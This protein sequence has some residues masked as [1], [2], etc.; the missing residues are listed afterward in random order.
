MIKIFG[1]YKF[2][3]D[4]NIITTSTKDYFD[5]FKE[6]IIN[7]F[8]SEKIEKYKI[9]KGMLTKVNI[10]IYFNILRFENLKLFK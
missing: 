1:Y 2:C 5:P 3:F 10:C 7:Y 8:N 4:C 6:K 9:K